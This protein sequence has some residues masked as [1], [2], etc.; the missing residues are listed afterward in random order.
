MIDRQASCDSP[1]RIRRSFGLRAGILRPRRG[2]LCSLSYSS[3][4]TIFSKR[5]S[6][7][8]LV[9]VPVNVALFPY[10]ELPFRPEGGKM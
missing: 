8:K 4:E 7:R 5:F 1:R 2:I 6:R 10:V 3:R 9:I